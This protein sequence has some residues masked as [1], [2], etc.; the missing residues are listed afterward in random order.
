MQYNFHQN[1]VLSETTKKINSKAI[2]RYCLTNEKEEKKTW[3][4]KTSVSEPTVVQMTT[5]RSVTRRSRKT[6]KEEHRLWFSGTNY[7][8]FVLVYLRQLMRYYLLTS[9]YRLCVGTKKKTTTHN[10]DNPAIFSI[11]TLFWDTKHIPLAIL[12]VSQYRLYTGT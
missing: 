11:Q 1:F 9:Q 4:S 5:T 7:I 2:K 8:D 3:N 10:L 12:V 6:V